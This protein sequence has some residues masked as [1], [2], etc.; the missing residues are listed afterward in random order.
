MT[1]P[2]AAPIT[3]GIVGGGQLGRMLAMA[4][5][6]LGMKTIIL[7][8]APDAPA[9]QL[10]HEQIVAAYDDLA[11]LAGLARQCDALTY[12][13][14]NVPAAGL[15]ALSAEAGLRP[16]RQALAVSQDRLDEKRFVESLGRGTVSSGRLPIRHRGCRPGTG[17]VTRGG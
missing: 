4:A 14:E 3:L 17:P 2:E 15:D 7:D 8:P 13:F 5:A 10:A 16:G 12:E 11:T 6:R 9:A 1:E